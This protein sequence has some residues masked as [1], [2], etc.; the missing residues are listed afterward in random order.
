M[1]HNNSSR[2]SAF[3][4]SIFPANRVLSFLPFPSIFDNPFPYPQHLLW[5]I[6]ES[7]PNQQAYNG[8]YPTCITFDCVPY[9]SFIISTNR[10][11]KNA[12]NSIITF[13][14]NNK[15]HNITG[16]WKIFETL[17]R[18]LVFCFSYENV[19]HLHASPW[20]SC[21]TVDKQTRQGKVDYC[22]H[23][24]NWKSWIRLKFFLNNVH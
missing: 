7:I 23:N 6:L 12:I 24:C 9:S 20:I 4:A 18:T 17:S 3:L 15:H 16:S 19:Q 8:E 13:V 21:H 5:D 14:R 1:A 22:W 11:F 2:I 10:L